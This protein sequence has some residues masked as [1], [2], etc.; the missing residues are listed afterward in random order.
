V[1][2]IPNYLP[3]EASGRVYAR[4]IKEVAVFEGCVMILSISSGFYEIVKDFQVA[5]S[6]KEYSNSVVVA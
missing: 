1:I 4:S 5:P 3:V 6:S 2:T